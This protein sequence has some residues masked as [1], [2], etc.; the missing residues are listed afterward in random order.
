MSKVIGRQEPSPISKLPRYHTTD[1]DDA[2]FLA[3]SYGLKPDPWQKLFLDHAMGRDA[4]GRMTCTQ[5]CLSLARQNGKSA[6]IEVIELYHMIVLGR[7]VLHTAHEVRTARA[8]FL[9]LCSFFESS[10]YPELQ[11]MV[12]HIRRANGQEEI[13]LKNGGSVQLGAR[14][15]GA[16]RGFTVD[17]L[18]MDEAQ[19]LG[20][21]SLAAL[22]PTISSAPSGEPQQII[23]G[24]PPTTKSDSEVWRRLRDSAMEGKNKRSMWCEWSAPET[25]GPIDLS[26]PEVWAYANP[27]LGIRL[28][29]E[30]IEDELSAMEPGV[31]MRERLGMWSFAGERSVI[32]VDDW[33]ACEDREA[34]VLPQDIERVVLSADITPSRDGGALVAAIQA[35]DGRP[36]IVDV[37]DQRAG[38]VAWIPAKI[39]DVVEKFG[40]DAVIIDGYSPASSLVEDIQARGVGVTKVRVNFVCTAAERFMDAVLTQNVRQ[41]GQAAMQL[42][43]SGA[44]KRKVGEGRFAFG[45]LNSTTDISPLVAATL[46]LHGLDTDEELSR[47]KYRKKTRGG[48]KKNYRK[49]VMVL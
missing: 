13:K 18:I 26:D 14:S 20:D 5:A 39:A 21:E 46:A 42:A 28:R 36:P 44:R 23:V 31:F 9:R 48:G 11:E 24:T 10:A 19:D 15:Q 29:H 12:E 8:A 22:L 40:A 38:S 33:R 16:G 34:R 32:P 47:V 49:R 4:K 7:K 30:V 6:I 17:T 35:N 1:G 25:D 45:R 37:I 2:A 27:S 43:L 3:A 41:L